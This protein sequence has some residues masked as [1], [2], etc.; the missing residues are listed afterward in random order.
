MPKNGPEAYY[1]ENM[2]R[3]RVV[4]WKDGIKVS[5]KYFFEDGQTVSSEI[6]YDK[7]GKRHGK[8]SRFYTN[9]TLGIEEY[10]KNGFNHG[11]TT[12]FH[13]N[14]QKLV[15]IN[16]L[17][18]YRVGKY[19]RWREDGK[20]SAEGHYKDGMKDGRWAREKIIGTEWHEAE[21]KDDV[22]ISGHYPDDPDLYEPVTFDINAPWA[23]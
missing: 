9:G 3:S 1:Y 21:F 18:G 14:G 19:T 6:N 7:L 15:E 10:F 13:S 22:C 17:D 8:S 2:H 11:K 23:R 16:Y 12:Y 4:N 20:K 5:E